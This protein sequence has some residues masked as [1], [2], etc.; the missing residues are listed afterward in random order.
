LASKKAQKTAGSEGL[1]DNP[2]LSTS[3]RCGKPEAKAEAARRSLG[4][5]GPMAPPEPFPS[6]MAGNARNLAKSREMT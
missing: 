4:E 5:G 6:E 2:A 3:L 1:L